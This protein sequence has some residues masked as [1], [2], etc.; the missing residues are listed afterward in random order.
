V[1]V[2]ELWWLTE[3]GIKTCTL[4]N[5]N[6]LL[7]SPRKN[8]FWHGNYPFVTVSTSPDLFKIQG[9]SLVANVAHLQD[10]AHS[11]LNQSVDNMEL[12]NNFI[13]AIDTTR[14][15]PDNL[16]RA[17]GEQW[18][19]EGPINEIIQQFV[20]STVTAQVALPY[21]GMLENNMQNLAGGH[22]FTTTSEAGRQGSDTATEASL[23]SNIAQASARQMKLRLNYAYERIGQQRLELNQQFIRRP[24][25]VETIGLDQ[26]SEFVEIAPWL[27]QGDQS[28]DLEPMGE[29]LMRQERRAEAN[30]M[31]QTFVQV[32]GPWLAMAQ[33]GSATPPNADA[34]I[35]QWLKEY[36][37]D[38]T[39]FF[40]A[41]PP[42]PTPAG[43]PGMGGGQQ[44]Q[45]QQP[46]TGG[47]MTAPE[48]VNPVTSPSNAGSISPETM[49]QRFMAQRG[50][51]NNA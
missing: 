4:G 22:P 29:S 6:V 10:A 8:P 11:M 25:M 7:K 5:R 27:L 50:G 28:F 44:P 20:P 32:V 33:A 26:D 23:V 2:L 48:A 43:M 49:M 39:P 36:V 3:D 13:V 1:E 17:P 35:K 40:S 18:E 12:Q 16:V 41:K 45:Q 38:P 30:A 14:V 24:V 31:L 15:D 42:P 19:V 21:I 46:M 37:D 9:N 51:A 47:G 34:F